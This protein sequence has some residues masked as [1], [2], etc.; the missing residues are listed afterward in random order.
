[1]DTQI[2]KATKQQ[3]QTT[4]KKVKYQGTESFI[5]AQTGEL[6]EM[7]VTDIEERDF[8]FSKIWMRNF[9]STLDLVGNQKTKLCFWVIDNLDRENKLCYSYSQIA[10]LSEISIATVKT[11]MKI[12]LDADFLRRVGTVYMV[13][14]D[15]VFKGTHRARLNILS[16]YHEAPITKMS[17][18]EKISCLKESIRQLQDRLQRLENTND[19][20]VVDAEVDGQL[21]M[22]GQ[23]L[24]VVERAH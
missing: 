4:S 22:M 8:N 20:N 13:N 23:N 21:T 5:N 19:T 17:D 15:I 6:I 11:T 3:T 14:P 2:V 9:I 16:Q 24:T 12:L 10:T 1:M 7:Q 18:A